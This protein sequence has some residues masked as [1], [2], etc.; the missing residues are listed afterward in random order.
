MLRYGFNSN[1]S[2][3]LRKI[4]SG[5]GYVFTH[6]FLDIPTDATR[7]IRFKTNDKHSH[8]VIKIEAEGKSIF[9][10]YANTTYV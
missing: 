2:E 5:K 6:I 4:L 3:S 9:K 8:V 10:T 1:I 7:Y